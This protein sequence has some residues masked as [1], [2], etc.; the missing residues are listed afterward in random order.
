MA[1]GGAAA[2]R[3]ASLMMT[4]KA[5]AFAQAAAKVAAGA[6]ARSVVNGYRK[7]VR[8]NRRRLTR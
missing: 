5:T 7:K 4:E 3:E 8:A 2:F 1:L 6:T